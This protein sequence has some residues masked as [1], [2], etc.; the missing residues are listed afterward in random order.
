[1]TVERASN[2]DIAVNMRASHT[3][4]QQKISATNTASDQMW[5]MVE[6]SLFFKSY[7][8]E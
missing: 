7:G 4:W 5:N 6:N 3:S 2:M 8:V 1:M